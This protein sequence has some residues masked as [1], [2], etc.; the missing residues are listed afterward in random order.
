MISFYGQC[1]VCNFFSQPDCVVERI[2]AWKSVKYLGGYRKASIELR[3]V[4][5][6]GRDAL[7]N[8]IRRLGLKTSVRRNHETERK[9][10][11]KERSA[12][13]QDVNASVVRR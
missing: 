10:N 11:R 12:L 7:D 6:R 5:E 3:S 1:P 4:A 2:E 9:I 13:D 8:S